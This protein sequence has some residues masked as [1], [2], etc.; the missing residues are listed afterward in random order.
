MVANVNC[1]TIGMILEYCYWETS[2]TPQ[3]PQVRHETLDPRRQTPDARPQTTSQ[4]G[5]IIGAIAVIY[6]DL[7]ADRL[8][9]VPI[10]RARQFLSNSGELSTR[11]THCSMPTTGDKGIDTG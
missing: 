8:L 3:T 9:S 7:K 5:E 1:A 6:L 2:L 11:P 4:G 10:F